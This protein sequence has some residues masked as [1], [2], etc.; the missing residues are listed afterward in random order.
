MSDYSN[1]GSIQSYLT[2]L[3]TAGVKIK[4]DQI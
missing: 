3:K 1:D 2:R 4:E